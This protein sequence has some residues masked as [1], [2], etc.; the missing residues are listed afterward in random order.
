V[1]K[2]KKFNCADAPIK[3]CGIPN[4]ET[5]KSYRR[6]PDDVRAAVPSLEWLGRRAMGGRVCFKTDAESFSVHLEFKT[7]SFDKGM[8]IYNCQSIF[9]FAGQRVHGRFLGLAGPENYE[10]KVFDATF[11]KGNNLLEDI[12]IYLPRNEE[13]G[14]V[15]ISVDDSASLCA[16][17]P[18]KYEKPIVFYGSSI[19]EGGCCCNV[20]NAYNA[21]VCRHLDSDFINLGF[22][23]N[24]KGEIEI[25]DFINTLEMSV[26]VLDYDHNAPTVLHL[27]NTHEPF[28]KRIRKAN[29][30]LP[31]LMMTRPK[32]AYNEEEKARREVVIQT[33]NNALAAGDKN[34]YFLDGETFYGEADRD[35]CTVDTIHPNDLGFYRMAQV[36][37]PVLRKI[38]NG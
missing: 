24:A 31:V 19:T 33:Y 15:E 37:E 6:L 29:P 10:Q 20:S 8:S 12:V 3:V 22:S 13:V 2:L 25:A 16:P 9:V 11:Y 7:L 35:A 5:T 30:F 34:V 27:K 28:F 32:I 4:F 36:I 1:E 26:F 21:I 23:G 18:Y 14:L 17:T 38:L